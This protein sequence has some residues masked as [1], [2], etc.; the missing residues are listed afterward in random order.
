[1]YCRKCWRDTQLIVF[2][3][4][5]LL[6]LLSIVMARHAP[7]A[8]GVMNM[9]IDG[10]NTFSLL[11]M[12][13][14]LSAWMLGSTGVARD[15]SDRKIANLSFKTRP[16]DN[17]VWAD[18]GVVLGEIVT[19]SCLTTAVLAAMLHFKLAFF[20]IGT[21]RTP[22]PVAH[23]GLPMWAVVAVTS[24]MSLFAGLLFSVAYLFNILVRRRG[25]GMTLSAAAFAVYFILRF[26]LSKAVSPFRINLPKL[27]FNP[28]DLQS[29]GAHFTL[30]LIS[31]ITARAAVVFAILYLSKIS[32]DRWKISDETSAT[33]TL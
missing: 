4:L 11:F 14:S 33:A 5:S 15:A 26:E 16:K 13:L 8:L 19:L 10:W 32:V 2:G 30:R 3:Y 6:L 7:V 25:A 17:H 24:T 12:G 9:G 1:M 20:D 23:A 31:S 22:S 28:F 29:S 18:S 21:I 27:I